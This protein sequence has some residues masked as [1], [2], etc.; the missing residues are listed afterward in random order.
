MRIVQLY[1]DFQSY[2][3][4]APKRYMCFVYYATKGSSLISKAI[5]IF[6]LVVE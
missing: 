5:L 4:S 6:L 1:V 3:D 2:W